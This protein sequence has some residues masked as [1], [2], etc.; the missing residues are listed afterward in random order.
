MASSARATVSAGRKAWCRLPSRSPSPSRIHSERGNQP[1]ELTRSMM[2]SSP[3]RKLGTD[4]TPKVAGA[5]DPVGGGIL[6]VR[7]PHGQRHGDQQ[8]DE[9]PECGDLEADGQGGHDAVGDVALRRYDGL[10]EV[11]GEDAAQPVE[12][13]GD[14]RLVEAEFR[15]EL[16]VLGGRPAAAEDVDGGVTGQQDH[17][18]EDPHARDEEHAQQFQD[19]EGRS[20]QRSE[21]H[22]FLQICPVA[23]HGSTGCAPR[24]GEAMGGRA[25]RPRAVSR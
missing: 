5:D 23:V 16:G 1:A 6:P 19:F 21:T 22:G 3:A 17:Q 18:G 15:A 20:A 13:A 12:V 25:S 2:S 7:R 10:A 11:P 4:S 8:G 9:Q 24:C 14:Q